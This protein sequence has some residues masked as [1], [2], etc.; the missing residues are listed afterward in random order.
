MKICLNKD[1]L[2]SA[3]VGYELRR[4]MVGVGSS[5]L[6]TWPLELPQNWEHVLYVSRMLN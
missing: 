6:W 2:E 4:K 5:I 3:R 1:S